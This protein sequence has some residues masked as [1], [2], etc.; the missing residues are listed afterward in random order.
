M[1]I[2]NVSIT[3]CA[4]EGNNIKA[5]VDILIDNCFA[6]KNIRIVESKKGGYFVAMPSVRDNITGKFEDVVYPIN[7]RTRD[8][9]TEKIIN[10]FQQEVINL[11]GSLKITEGY[12]L[13]VNLDN[14]H[15]VA[16][17][18]IANNKIIDTYDVEDF[19][20]ET[21]EELEIEVNE[22]YYQ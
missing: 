1:K 16:L 19:K 3:L 8:M 21:L 15:D 14:I 11:L 10:K 4:V 2:T 17:V 7:Q 9:F 22:K 12:D 13:K 5:G 20:S 18:D 6:I